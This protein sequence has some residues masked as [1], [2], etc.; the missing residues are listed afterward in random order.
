[1]FFDKIKA[2]SRM[3]CDRAH[4]YDAVS[5]FFEVLVSL[6]ESAVVNFP[7]LDDRMPV[8]MFPSNKLHSSFDK[9]KFRSVV[10][11]SVIL[12]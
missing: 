4:C 5:T 9:Q 1:M 11:T 7:N 10:F 2:L 8:T 12:F 3:M 6:D